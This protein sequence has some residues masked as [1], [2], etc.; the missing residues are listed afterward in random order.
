MASP[1]G[2]QAADLLLPAAL[3]KLNGLARMPLSTSLGT[4]QGG[5]CCYCQQTVHFSIAFLWYN[6][7]AFHSPVKVSADLFVFSD[8]KQEEWREREALQDPF[9]KVLNIHI[10]IVRTRNPLQTLQVLMNCCF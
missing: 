10:C 4:R 9:G 5:W 8:Y 6:L 1:L 3:V 7:P 2:L